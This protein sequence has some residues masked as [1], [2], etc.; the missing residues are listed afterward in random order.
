MLM[1]LE[2]ILVPTDFSEISLAAFQDAVQLI[3]HTQIELY[4]LHVVDS[5]DQVNRAKLKLDLMA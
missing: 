2:R 1:R 5:H 3:K 4:H